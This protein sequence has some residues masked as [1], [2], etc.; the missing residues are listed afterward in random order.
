MQQA[1]NNTNGNTGNDSA[2]AAEAA[3]GVLAREKNQAVQ[4]L[5]KLTRNLTDL[6]ERE[7]QALAQND[8]V[9]FAILQDE[10]ALIA[11]HYAAASSEFRARLPE[12]RGMNPD[13]LDRLESLQVRLGE[14]ARQNNDTVKRMYSQSKENTQNTLISAQELGQSKPMRFAND[15]GETNNEVN[16]A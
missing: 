14:A 12:F 7:S 1:A 2:M 8:M 11:E 6:A 10:K 9:S 16:N 5:I 15:M 4:Q 13:L 3:A